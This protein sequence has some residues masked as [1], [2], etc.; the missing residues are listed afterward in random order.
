[1]ARAQ[2]SRAARRAAAGRGHAAIDQVARDGDEVDVEA[3]DLVDDALQVVA[4]DRGPDVQVA[5]LRDEEAFERRRQVTQ[6]HVDGLHARRAARVPE[7]HERDR[8]RRDR[9]GHR[10]ATDPVGAE[11]RA[12]REMHDRGRRQRGIAQQRQDEQRREQAHEPQAHPGEPV[13]APLLG[14]AAAP[15]MAAQRHRHQQR[16]GQQQHAE[17]GGARQARRLREAG[18][19]AQRDVGVRRERDRPQP[20]H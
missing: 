1:M 11:R 18:Q 9:R 2:V 7:A 4:L 20:I 14:R 16:R 6:R 13:V 19:E 12:A 8:E 3:V 10:A 15:A 17:R 5:D